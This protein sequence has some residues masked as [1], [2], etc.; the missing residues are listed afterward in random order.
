MNQM[1]LGTASSVVAGLLTYFIV[2]I[3]AEWGALPR[4]AV[5]LGVAAVA[6]GLGFRAAEPRRDGGNVTIGSDVRGRNATVEGIKVRAPGGS[7]VTVGKKVRAKGKRG[8]AAVKGVDVGPPSDE[9]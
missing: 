5:V 4:W 1:A 9:A 8:D 2:E 3:T 7:N 6:G